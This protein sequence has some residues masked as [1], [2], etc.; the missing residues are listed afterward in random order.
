MK[1]EITPQSQGYV[2]YGSCRY[3]EWQNLAYE[4]APDEQR[5]WPDQEWIEYPENSFNDIPIELFARRIDDPEETAK[6]AAVSIHR[7]SKAIMEGESI[8]VA[9]GEINAVVD[10]L[11]HDESFQSSANRDREVDPLYSTD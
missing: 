3:K 5:K 1:G 4:N 9:S 10:I 6:E 2:L 11:S 7:V 8:K